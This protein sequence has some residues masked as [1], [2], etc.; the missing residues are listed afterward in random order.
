MVRLDKRQPMSQRW[1]CEQ[2]YQDTA[3]LLFAHCPGSSALHKQRSGLQQK[4]SGPWGSKSTVLQQGK[5]R[6][7]KEESGTDT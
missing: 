4:P 6:T 2:C 7:G 5:E 3:C 1:G